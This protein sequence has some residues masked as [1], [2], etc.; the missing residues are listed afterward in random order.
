[1]TDFVI[2]A[3]GQSLNKQDVDYVQGKARVIAVSNAFE[4][5]QWA[6]ALVSYDAKWWKN[7][8]KA[9]DFAGEKICWQTVTGVK[10]VRPYATPVGCNSGL[11]AMHIARDLGASRI[12]LL[13]FDMHGTHFFGP[14]Q[15][16]LKNT[17]AGRFYQH[18]LQFNCWKYCEVVNCTPNSQI[19]KFTKK[20]L[21]DVI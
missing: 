1:M 8:P 21:R 9:L 5:A 6:E 10:Q 11:Y 2:I 4:F 7:T 17:S 19:E 3:T 14:H 18:I 20:D 15:E 16:P 12:I 13:G